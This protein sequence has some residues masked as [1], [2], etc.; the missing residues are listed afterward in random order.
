MRA[1]APAQDLLPLLPRELG[2]T[3]HDDALLLPGFID[4][5]SHYP[6]T[7]VIASAG[8]PL[9][10][11]LDQAVFPEERRFGD[12]AH[13]GEVAGFFLDQLLRNGTTTALVFASVHRAS[14]D[15]FFEAAG[16]RRLRMIAGKLL[17]DQNCPDF[18][19]DSAVDGER[20]TRALIER[21]HGR[22]RLSYAITPRFAATSSAA[23]LHGAGRL[24]AEHPDVFIHS[25]LAENRAE[26]A[27]VRELFPEARSYLDVYDRCGLLR[28]RA[29]YA[30]C[31][32]LD[33]TDRRRMAATGAA[34]AFCPSSNLFLGSGL[35]DLAASDAAGLRYGIGTDVGAGTRFGLLETLGE[36][37]KVAAL[38]GQALS[39][40][41]AFYLATLGGARS[42][43]LER[44][45][46]SFRPGSE[47]DFVV[48][49]FKATPLIERRCRRAP[50]LAEKLLVLMMLGDDRAIRQTYV[51]GAESKPR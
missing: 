8:G 15:A 2:V 38:Q 36:A 13:A 49:D 1:G 14:V 48:L 39:P 30:H 42:L 23:Q 10:S 18:L 43:G 4:T 33:D 40:L 3:R 46:G 20:D 35:F 7:D 47:A 24:A 44:E 41:R 37:Y 17:M 32:H 25:H 22:E 21:W 19:R 28:E 51:L 6:Q 34:A 27:W 9:L 26:I 16:R 50:T 11:W 31:L 45:I 12:A 29:V 5:H